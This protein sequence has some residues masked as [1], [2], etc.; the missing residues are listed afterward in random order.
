MISEIPGGRSTPPVAIR[1]IR[2]GVVFMVYG[3]IGRGCNTSSVQK[4]SYLAI[5]L[6]LL[7]AI[8]EYFLTSY[9]LE[10]KVESK[11]ANLL[12]TKAVLHPPLSRRVFERFITLYRFTGHSY[13][14]SFSE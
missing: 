12:S 7:K 13:R 6:P 4:A 9:I 10:K 11:R 3:S 14:I 8:L 1:C 5:F 2:I